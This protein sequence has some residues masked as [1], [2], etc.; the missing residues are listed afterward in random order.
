MIAALLV[1]ALL[2]GCASMSKVSMPGVSDATGVA[3]KTLKK[4]T[5]E[6][7]EVKIEKVTWTSEVW[8]DKRYGVKKTGKVVYH[9]PKIGCKK[10]VEA[11]K[12]K[13]FY[14][15]FYDS[16][17]LKLPIEVSFNAQ[18]GKCGPIPKPLRFS[19]TRKTI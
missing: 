7:L 1:I 12:G 9:L 6:V 10:F 18:E 19:Y 11:T 5:V 4:P 15:E 13:E 2:G 17:G 16:K 3:K 8:G 14:F